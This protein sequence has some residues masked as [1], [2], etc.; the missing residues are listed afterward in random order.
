MKKL[1][2][3][4]IDD[5]DNFVTISINPKIFPLEVIYL[6]SYVFMDRAYVM[7]NG[8]PEKE[9]LVQL[10]SK[11]KKE[12]LKKLAS[13]FNNELL[14]YSVYVVQAARTNELRR[15]IIERALM[16]NTIE[17]LCQCDEC[18]RA[19]GEL[20][21]ESCEEV[22]FIE[23]PEGIAKPWTPE[24]SYELPDEEEEDIEKIKKEIEETEKEMKPEQY[25]I[26]DPEGIANPKSLSKQ[27]DD[28]E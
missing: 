18:R 3:F 15:A 6:A 14:N 28:K 2:N 8:D 26:D 11:D 4:E 23:D 10:K 25:E 12:N 27:K 17:E 24:E 19:R 7:L 9:V 22:E 20:V 13:E 21:D 5:E 1:T 16:T